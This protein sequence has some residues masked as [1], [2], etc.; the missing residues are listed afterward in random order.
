[1]TTSLKQQPAPLPDDVQKR[2]RN[3]VP[4]AI[5]P[6]DWDRCRAAVT[7]LVVAAPPEDAADAADLLSSSV[8]FLAFAAAKAGS[9][10]ITELLDGPWL[11][12]FAA[13]WRAAGRPDNT[14]RNHLG[15]LHRLQRTATGGDG[16]RRIRRI[17]R[18]P[19]RTAR[20][21]GIV[22]RQALETTSRLAPDAVGP[23][24]RLALQLADRGIVVPDA[25]GHGLDESRWHEAQRWVQEH[26]L[27][28]LDRLQ[29]RRMWTLTVAS[30]ATLTEALRQGVTRNELDGLRP[31]LSKGDP[32]TVRARLRSF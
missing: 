8:A 3:Y 11:V 1:M 10:Q 19:G 22:E 20:P 24:I 29:L 17:D 9:W 28:T 16:S 32:E 12:R 7:N 23:T 30:T 5:S 4:R 15:A 6:A 14:L 26:R 2:I 13:E 21:Y 18:E 31:H 25:Y 27:P